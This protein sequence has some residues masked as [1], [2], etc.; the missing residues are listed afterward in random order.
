MNVDSVFYQGSTHPICQDYATVHSNDAGAFAFLADGCSGSPHTDFGARFLVHSAMQV[1]N[2][3]QDTLKRTP[4]LF[5]D[6]EFALRAALFADRYRVAVGLSSQSI[7]ATLLGLFSQD[8]LIYAFMYGDGCLVIGYGDESYDFYTT[9]YGMGYPNYPSYAVDLRRRDDFIKQSN[10]DVV[11]KKCH[12][13]PDGVVTT[14]GGSDNFNSKIRS[15]AEETEDITSPT[16]FLFRKTEDIKFVAMTSD[17]IETFYRPEVKETSTTNIH[18]PAEE[19]IRKMF[20]FKNFQGVFLQRRLQRFVRDTLR[21]GWRH[22]DDLSV[23]AM[24]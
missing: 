14:L 1:S 17:G 8:D 15:S 19:V 5:C 3:T 12:I 16:T 11:I 13:D 10:D 7:D 9:E 24:G 4:S 18:I 22:E 21:E 20:P 2:Q 6:Q 23:I